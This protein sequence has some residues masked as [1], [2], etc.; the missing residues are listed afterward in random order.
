MPS[1][2]SS[3][4]SSFQTISYRVILTLIY[5]ELTISTNL[6]ELRDSV[7]SVYIRRETLILFSK[8]YRLKLLTILN[9]HKP[10]IQ[11]STCLKAAL[12]CKFCVHDAGKRRQTVLVI[13][14][15]VGS[16]QQFLNYTFLNAVYVLTGKKLHG[17]FN[18]TGQGSMKLVFHRGNENIYTERKFA[19]NTLV[20]KCPAV[21]AVLQQASHIHIYTFSNVM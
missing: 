4:S 14:W 13:T 19:T 1:T 11:N 3:M 7:I 17:I 12:L 21:Y 18:T 20:H 15:L 2:T 16:S 10:T 5:N 9:T 8:E 6:T